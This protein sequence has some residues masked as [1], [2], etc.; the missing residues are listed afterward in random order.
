MTVKDSLCRT[1][2]E[3]KLFIFSCTGL[4]FQRTGFVDHLRIHVRGGPGGQ[5]FPKYGGLGGKGGDV[6]LEADSKVYLKHLKQAP[7]GL[8]YAGGAGTNSR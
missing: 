1:W 4:F 3:P 2:S 7:G 6:I 8:R 5:G